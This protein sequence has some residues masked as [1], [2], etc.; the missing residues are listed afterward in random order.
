MKKHVLVGS[1]FTHSSTLHDTFFRSPRSIIFK[2]NAHGGIKN[3]SMTVYAVVDA[4]L[5][6]EYRSA[7]RCELFWRKPAPVMV[8]VAA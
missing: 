2:Q 4:D 1:Q 6:A 5:F 3:A 7:R 8:W